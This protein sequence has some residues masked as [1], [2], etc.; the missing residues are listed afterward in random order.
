MVGAGN[1]FPS[2][3]AIIPLGENVDTC[4]V[5]KRILDFSK[6]SNV[7]YSDLGQVGRVLIDLL[8]DY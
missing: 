1:A 5:L 2:A 3:I 6:G 7:R 4:S 8:M